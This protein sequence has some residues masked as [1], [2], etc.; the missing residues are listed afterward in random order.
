LCHLQIKTAPFLM[1]FHFKTALLNL[2]L[3]SYP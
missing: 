2:G 1:D 3:L